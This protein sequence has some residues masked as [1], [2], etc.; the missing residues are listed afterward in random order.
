L[1]LRPISPASDFSDKALDVAWDEGGFTP[2][3]QYAAFVF[4]RDEGHLRI[5]EDDLDL[6]V[7]IDSQARATG[8][9]PD[10]LTNGRD[11]IVQVAWTAQGARHLVV[12]TDASGGPIPLTAA[13]IEVFEDPRCRREKL[14]T[15]HFVKASPDEIRSLWSQVTPS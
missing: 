1:R 14:E 4:D 6:F 5:V 12:S 7:Q 10:S 8:V 2:T 9:D 13:E 3:L 11:W 15:R